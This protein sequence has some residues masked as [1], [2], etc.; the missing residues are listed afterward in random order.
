MQCIYKNV[1]GNKSVYLRYRCSEI[2][3]NPKYVKVKNVSICI[4]NTKINRF[5]KS[6]SY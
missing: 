1:F 5:I 3:F 4:E 2:N 6:G